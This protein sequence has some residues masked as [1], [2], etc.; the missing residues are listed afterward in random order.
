M[1]ELG[2]KLRLALEARQTLR[3]GGEGGGEDL[4]GHLAVELRVGG[5]V[6]LAHAALAQ[7]SGD[8][9]GAQRRSDQRSPLPEHPTLRCATPRLSP[10]LGAGRVS[11]IRRRCESPPTATRKAAPRPVT[12]NA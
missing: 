8:P 1:V 4:D 12:A 7:P 6:H 11:E 5:A 9:I 3:V 2:E 10:V